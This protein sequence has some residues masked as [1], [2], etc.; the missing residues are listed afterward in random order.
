M[1]LLLK[2]PF[3]VYFGIALCI[4]AVS[5]AS[6]PN[7]ARYMPP[8]IAFAVAA[9]AT[10]LGLAIRI[11]LRRLRA[12]KLQQHGATL[13]TIRQLSWHQFEALIAACYT[14]QGFA[15][16]FGTRVE[17]C[18]PECVVVSR[19]RRRLLVHCKAFNAP[20]CDIGV[21]REAN[22]LMASERANACAVVTAGRVTRDAHAWARRNRIQLI[23]GRALEN[24]V[25]RAVRTLRD[26][27][28]SSGA[29]NRPATR[30][31]AEIPRLDPPSHCAPAGLLMLNVDCVIPPFHCQHPERSPE[32]RRIL[33]RF[34]EWRIALI[35]TDL[36][37]PTLAAAA[38]R[39]PSDLRPFVFGSTMQSTELG[40]HRR[41]RDICRFLQSSRSNALP[42][43]IIDNSPMHYPQ[44]APNLV[45][46]DRDSGLDAGT[47][48]SVLALIPKAPTLKEI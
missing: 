16:A 7:A 42:V 38:Q 40:P 48:E 3:A 23:S 37:P 6:A 34:P 24:L 9:S 22:S 13:D 30:L 27:Q 19:H 25:L 33:R 26:R 1:A 46:A 10:A 31:Y 8:L 32:L 14:S 5:V 41:Y 44:G 47:A 15:V 12:A 4:A 36:S 20:V 35:Q 39:L 17:S 43:C 45:V 29:R 28:P 11:C 2:V 21:V 18:V